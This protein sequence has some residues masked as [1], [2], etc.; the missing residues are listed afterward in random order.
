MGNKKKIF[1]RLFVPLLLWSIIAL[2]I[3]LLPPVPQ[4]QGS[5]PSDT[6]SYYGNDAPLA[7]QILKYRTELLIIILICAVTTEF[8]FF[9]F[10]KRKEQKK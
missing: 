3:L 7:R 1:W 5:I 10:E 4:E 9:F 2:S 6:W 8:L